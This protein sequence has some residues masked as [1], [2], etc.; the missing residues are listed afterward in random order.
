MK[1][2]LFFGLELSYNKKIMI[3]LIILAALYKMYILD[4]KD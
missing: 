1:N 4:L 3:I 2:F